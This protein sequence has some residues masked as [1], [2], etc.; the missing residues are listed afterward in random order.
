MAG[1]IV[2][3]YDDTREARAALPVAV[4]LARSLGAKLVI[5]FGF[6]PPRSGERS[7]PCAVRSRSSAR[8]SPPR[9][10]PRS[11]TWT[12]TSTSRCS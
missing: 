7:V 11:T 4:E 5:G 2:L 6:E 8:S 3:G 10:W 9:R 12:R 1:E